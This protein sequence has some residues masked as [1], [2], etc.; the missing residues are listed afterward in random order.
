MD[1]FALG[2]VAKTKR[3]CDGLMLLAGME[4]LDETEPVSVESSLSLG[5]LQ[6][7][8]NKKSDVVLYFQHNMVHTDN[9]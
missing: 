8:Q 1:L 9:C 6:H 5:G 4:G 7:Q 2:G 3:V